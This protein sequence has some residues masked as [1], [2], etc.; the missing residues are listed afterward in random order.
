MVL[1]A[2]TYQQV[3]EVGEVIMCFIDMVTLYN[4]V[5]RIQTVIGWDNYQTDFK[6]RQEQNCHAKVQDSVPLSV[7]K[8]KDKKFWIFKVPLKAFKV[9][10][11]IFF[12]RNQL[13]PLERNSSFREANLILKNE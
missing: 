12:T 8:E 5:S 6:F 13:T 11:N 9:S 7:L 1:W 4:P 3:K 2:N 10:W